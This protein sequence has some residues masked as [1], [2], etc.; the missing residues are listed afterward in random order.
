MF[1]VPLVVATKFLSWSSV[2]VIPLNK[3]KLSTC[4]T[5]IVILVAP[6]ITGGS[7]FSIVV[8]SFCITL[9]S[10]LSS[11]VKSLNWFV[12]LVKILLRQVLQ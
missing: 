5:L 7:D 4:P 1:I 11:E 3:L 12:P 6:F 2:T 10:I 9:A 8:L